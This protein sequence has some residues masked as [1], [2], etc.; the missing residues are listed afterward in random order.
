M[1]WSQTP[2]APLISYFLPSAAVVLLVISVIIVWY[3]W[4]TFSCFCCSHKSESYKID[5]LQTRMNKVEK[6]AQYFICNS[7]FDLE[8]DDL[9]KRLE[10]RQISQSE[11]AA[12]D[13]PE[14]TA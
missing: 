4:K 10:M 7:F 8:I 12:K 11:K 13:L 3:L 1:Y 2:S 6:F 14:D 5:D 9:K